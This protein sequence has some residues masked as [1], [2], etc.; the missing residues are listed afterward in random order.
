MRSPSGVDNV[1][2]SLDRRKGKMRGHHRIRA[3]LALALAASAIPAVAAS[4]TPKPASPKSSI[5]GNVDVARRIEGGKVLEVIGWAADMKKGTVQKVEIRLNDK[6]VGIAQLGMGRE[7]VADTFRRKDLLKSGW[8][9]R[10]N[11]NKLP[12]GTYR[13]SAYAFS[14]KASAR[15]AMGKVEFRLP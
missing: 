10:V 3:V 11:L 7:D 15:L 5:R 13:L 8:T 9:A 12:P 1:R 4:P 2:V 14:G 6:P